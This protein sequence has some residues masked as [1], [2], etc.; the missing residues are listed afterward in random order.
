[1]HARVARKERIIV[2]EYYYDTG[3]MTG[4]LDLSNEDLEGGGN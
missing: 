3:L 1:M 4:A 2:F